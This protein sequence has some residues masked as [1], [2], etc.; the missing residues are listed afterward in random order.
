MT[1]RVFH[2]LHSIER[3]H[4][5]TPVMNS[6]FR[7]QLKLIYEGRYLWS[8][9]FQIFHI[10]KFYLKEWNVK[11]SENKKKFR[12][13]PSKKKKIFAHILMLKTT[14]RVHSILW[15]LL[16]SFS[17]LYEEFRYFIELCLFC[18]SALKYMYWKCIF[19]V[20][21]KIFIIISFMNIVLQASFKNLNEFL[22]I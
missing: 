21:Y 19:G 5:Y 1:T 10:Y 4:V 8:D 15:F 20:I 22:K 9:F 2:I 17:K 7:R 6:M 16:L 11:F 18:P 14:P 12:P 3:S 13:P